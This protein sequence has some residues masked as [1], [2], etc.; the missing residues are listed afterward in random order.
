MYTVFASI[1]IPVCSVSSV[2]RRSFLD[3]FASSIVRLSSDFWIFSPTFSASSQFISSL[4]ISPVDKLFKQ[5]S[6]TEKGYDH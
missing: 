2:L 1:T 6:L 3:I 4:A 5:G